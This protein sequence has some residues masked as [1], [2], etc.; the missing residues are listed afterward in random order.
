VS[1]FK[2][3][4]IIWCKQKLAIVTNYL[5]KT[6]TVKITIMH[7]SNGTWMLRQV[8]EYKPGFRVLL[9]MRVCQTLLLSGKSRIL[10]Y[11]SAVPLKSL[12]CR[13]WAWNKWRRGNLF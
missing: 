5:V 11:G 6:N 4:V 2:Y 8:Y 1:S 3:I 13:S 9:W 10:A 7:H 12:A